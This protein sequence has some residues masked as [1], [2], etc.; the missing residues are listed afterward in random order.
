MLAEVDFIFLY[1]DQ[2]GQTLFYKFFRGFSMVIWFSVQ[3]RKRNLIQDIFQ[4][5][6]V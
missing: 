2:S 4:I 1:L 3:L 5:Q 6:A